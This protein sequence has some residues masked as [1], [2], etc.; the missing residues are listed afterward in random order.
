MRFLVDE[1]FPKSLVTALIDRGHDVVW[2]TD[3]CKS[4]DDRHVLAIATTD[5]RIV[6]TED[7]D[8]G[9]LT[10]RD[11]Y[12]AVGIILAHA[13]RYPGGITSAVETLCSQIDALGSSLEGT[14]TVLTPD[15][16]RQRALDKDKTP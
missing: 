14:L 4:E 10:I 15:R 7:K 13:E 16:I 11:G 3:I 1:C 8:F 2:A 12:V 6:I 9:D 5:D